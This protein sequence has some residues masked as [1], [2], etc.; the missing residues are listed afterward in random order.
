MSL[1]ITCHAFHP[2]GPAL[3]RLCRATRRWSVLLLVAVLPLTVAPRIAQA[4]TSSASPAG[5]SVTPDVLTADTIPPT[6]TI[7]PSGGSFTNPSVAVTIGW[8]DNSSL[9]STARTVTLDG[10]PQSNT[11]TTGTKTGCVKYAT[12]TLTLS[13]PPGTH[14]LFASI[15]DA[16]GN[17]G[18]QS[19]VYSYTPYT[20]AVTADSSPVTRGPAVT[21]AQTFKVHSTGSQGTTYLLR[22]SCTGAAFASCSVPSSIALTTGQTATVTA[23][24][25][26]GST[27]TSG[28]LSL[29]AK[30]QP[31]TT[32]QNTATTTVNVVAAAYGVTVSGDSG[33]KTRAS[34]TDGATTYTV[35]NTGNTPTTYT[36]RLSCPS[37]VFASCSA[38]S[39]LTLPNG[40]SAKVTVGYT[41]AVGPA[42]GS[43]GLTALAQLDT[44]KQATG[45]D[46]I[47]VQAVPLVALV[48]ML[49]GTRER[50]QCL[51]FGIVR[52]LATDCGVIRFAEA[53]PTVTTYGKAR[54]PTLVYYVDAVHQQA[55]QADVTPRAGIT[56]DSVTMDLR[57]VTAGGEVEI[58]YR[59]F[60]G[61]GC[62]GCT[63]RIATVPDYPQTGIYKYHIYVKVYPHGAALPDT[64]SAFTEIPVVNHLASGFGAGWWLAGAEQL[65]FSQPDSAG[66]LWVGGDLSTRKYVWARYDPPTSTTYYVAPSITRPDTLVHNAGAGYAANPWYRVL[67]MKDTVFFNGSGWH[68][69]TVNHLGQ[70]TQLAWTTGNNSTNPKLNTLTVPGGLTYTWYRSAGVDSVAAPGPI[71]NGPARVTRLYH[72]WSDSL[73]VYGR[74]IR[75]ITG[76]AGDSVRFDFYT[77]EKWDWA[78]SARTDRRGTRT[79]IAWEGYSSDLS[80][81]TTPANPTQTVVQ[82]FRNVSAIGAPPGTAALLRDSVYTRYT[83]PRGNVT[84]W[85]VDELGAPTKIVNALNQTTLIRY[86]DGRFPGLA[87]ETV[88]PSGLVT[89][90]WYNARGL[91]DSTTTFN[92]YGD[93]RNATTTYAWDAKW[94]APIRTTAPEGETSSDSVDVTTGN[95]VW[96]ETGG[97]TTRFFY[98]ANRQLDSAR[99]SDGAVDAYT[100]DA[101]LRNLQAHKRPLTFSDAY[102]R[103]AIGR[104]TL[105][106]STTDRTTSTQNHPIIVHRTTYDAAD[107]DSVVLTYADA[108][109]L[110]VTTLYDKES[111]VLKVIQEA[112][113]ARAMTLDDTLLRQVTRSYRYDSI[114][115]KTSEWSGITEVDFW[116]YDLAGNHV[117]GGRELGNDVLTYDP[118]NRVI[119]RANGPD[120]ATYTYDITGGIRTANNLDAMVTRSYFPNGAVKGD[121]LSIANTGRT[122]FGTPYGMAFAYDR[123]GRRTSLQLP[124]AAAG[125]I[126]YQYDPRTGQI[127]SIT[128]PN[129]RRY[130]YH[131]DLRGRIDSLFR[132]DGQSDQIPETRTYDRESRIQTRVVGGFENDGPQYDP[133][134]R[135]VRNG[136]DTLSYYALG[137]LKYSYVNALTENFRYDA[138]GNRYSMSTSGGHA[139]NQSRD[140]VYEAGN[141]RQA[142]EHDLYAPKNDTTWHSYNSWGN[143]ATTTTNRWFVI[144]RPTNTNDSGYV[145]TT[146]TNY[147]ANSNRMTQTTYY[148]DSV[149]VVTTIVHYDSAY[150]N[151]EQYRYDALGRRVW[152]RMVHGSA[153]QTY[154]ASSGCI[155]TITQ[156]VWDG[157][158]VLLEKRTASD[159]GYI[160]QSQGNPYG[161]VLNVNGANID[162]PLALL[163]SGY[164][165][166][167]PIADYRRKITTGG[168]PTSLCNTADVIF[169][170]DGVFGAPYY[171]QVSPNYYGSAITGM[172]DG[173]GYQYRRN[174]YIDPNTGLFTQEDPLGLAG[175]LNVYG[176]GAGNPINFS[177]PFGLCPD[178]NDPRCSQG[179]RVATLTIGGFLGSLIKGVGVGGTAGLAVDN[180]GNMMLFASGGIA[181]QHGVGASIQLGSQ[182]GN[183][184][185][186]VTPTG[187][188]GGMSVTAVAE[189]GSVTIP[190]GDDGKANGLGFGPG[191]GLGGAA[192]STQVAAGTS[193]FTAGDIVNGLSSTLRDLKADW[194]EF[195]RQAANAMTPKAP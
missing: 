86:T 25:T 102:V 116:N 24:Y 15:Q 22:V 89:R 108:D 131:Y 83:D 161:L 67:P 176:F 96:A 23:T 128:D 100:Y 144:P 76:P 43:L 184:N 140:Y 187:K 59:P 169:E 54:T 58:N 157:S 134:G 57:K 110:R 31:D 71:T 121:T 16:A 55:I 56:V 139:S 44:T 192:Q 181:G 10:T 152:Q 85:W 150:R 162:E 148:Y 45:G 142:Q 138:L 75:T 132:R 91:V 93:G 141:G 2:L 145:L 156:T 99:T 191:A 38:P 78:Y 129:G 80:S 195:K 84:K 64:A 79:T 166:V 146:R 179:T 11:Y 46:G 190:V 20:V 186:L 18:V 29:T 109:S 164:H 37:A 155:S 70:V 163:K 94:P 39:A 14:T 90:S 5:G 69:K 170:D 143:L 153:C 61:W 114:G 119:K 98:N 12:S 113:P 101:A 97:D 1:P 13:L 194:D 105:D 81:A 117:S 42:S 27:V 36:L 124:S 26:T 74:G 87:T 107:R 133:Y 126:T 174:R 127:A 51:A 136:Q 147:Y 135:I 65:V 53:L 165:D 33:T 35:A 7:T 172:T 160:G 6:V 21:A 188:G 19:A 40:Q 3:R 151:L 4:Q 173:S 177:D 159:S 149:W 9:L 112:L 185:S 171:P 8:C 154:D 66:V 118:L 72:P 106:S 50:S 180:H 158:D 77:A 34:R 175:G 115:R 28:S 122:S 103:D 111:N 189:G 41:T 62:N 183:L 32:E 68:V 30:A 120:S 95:T 63:Q 193:P 88:S 82:S 168:C 49:P 178:S 92:M 125:T 48:N 167:L 182:R 17:E 52:G 60:A 73:Q 104:V 123:E 137:P 47:S 130:R